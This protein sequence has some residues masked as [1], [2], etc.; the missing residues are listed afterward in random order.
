M[1]N[2]EINKKFSIKIL[3]GPMFGCELHLP[4]DDYFLIINPSQALEDK[5]HDLRLEHDHAASYTQ[6]T[7]YIPC[8]TPSPNITLFLSNPSVKDGQAHFDVKVHDEEGES[9]VSSLKENAIFTYKHIRLAVKYDDDVWH[10]DIK[11]YQ[12]SQLPVASD[13]DAETNNTFSRKR[14]FA[15]FMGAAFLILLL[16]SAFIYYKVTTDQQVITLSEVLAGAPAPLKVIKG[17]DN[18]HVY[19]LAR[20]SREMEWA[21]EAVH[22]LKDQ[23]NIV[24]ILLSRNTRSVIS[25]LSHDGYPVLQF[26]NTVPERPTLAV[27]RTLT[28]NEASNLKNLVLQKLPY[29]SDI[30]FIT[31]SK[32]QLLADAQQGLDRLNVHYRLI[33]TANGYALVIRDSLSDSTLNSVLNFIKTYEQQWGDSVI[34]FSVNLDENWLQNKSYVD[35][36]KGYLFLNPRHWYFPL[37]NKDI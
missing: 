35:S 25:E 12:P 23:K 24:L 10:E 29:A 14:A 22:K 8:D 2:D 5:A 36:K 3:F 16:T 11:N 4:A 1:I 6:N 30:Q 27:Y 18:K 34:T 15:L 31:R 17:R 20:Q 7:L 32:K 19:I 13:N 28:P 21:K 26:D 37:N 9:T 33:T